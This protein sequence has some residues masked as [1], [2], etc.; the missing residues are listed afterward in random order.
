MELNAFLTPI[1]EL[2]AVVT[3]SALSLKMFV[4]F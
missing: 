3:V 4:D 1:D 2:L